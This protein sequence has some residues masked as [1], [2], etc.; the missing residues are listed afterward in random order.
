[1]HDAVFS[2]AGL[3]SGETY[4]LCSGDT[5][6]AT[7]TAGTESSAPGFQP[8]GD[9]GKPGDRP[10]VTLPYADVS[11]SDWFY[12]YV[13][14]A[15]ERAWMTGT[16]ETTFSPEE[17][18]TRAMLV[19]VLYRLEGKPAVDAASGFS[20]VSSGSYYA[21]AVAWAKANGI[22]NGTSETTFSPNEPVTREQTV[23]ILYRYAQYKGYDVEKTA[24]LTAY[25]DAAAIH[26]YAKNAMS[27]A[28]AAGILNG[29]SSTSL[30]P[31]GSATRAQVA[32]VLTRFAQTTQT[33]PAPPQQG[34]PDTN[35]A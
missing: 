34:A 7:A 25:A 10:D 33:P 18:T 19:T 1:M 22:V 16:S 11:Q 6:A 29:V 14:F 3:T 15:Y 8:G 5:E 26:S 4:T 28:V 24:D 20:D 35:A 32:T 23:A 27:W 2:S 17:T 30:E 21:D 12:P 13:A 31:T 9:P